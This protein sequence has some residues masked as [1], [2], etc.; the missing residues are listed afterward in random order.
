MTM[1]MNY[2]QPTTVII[3]LYYRHIIIK[4]VHAYIHA[5]YI[6]TGSTV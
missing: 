4:Y 5:Q 3:K 1:H 6:Y 2:S